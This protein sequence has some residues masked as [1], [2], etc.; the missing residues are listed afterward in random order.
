MAGPTSAAFVRS[1]LT[2]MSRKPRKSE[3]VVSLKLLIIAVLCCSVR[4]AKA[5]LEMLDRLAANRLAI[6]IFFSGKCIARQSFA[7]SENKYLINRSEIFSHT[8]ITQAGEAGSN[9]R[10]GVD[11]KVADD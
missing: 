7:G 2:S 5:G 11:S 6:R 3:T 8:T 10:F 9:V 1:P 4:L